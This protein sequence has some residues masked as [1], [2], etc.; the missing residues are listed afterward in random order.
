MRTLRRICSKSVII[1]VNPWLFWLRTADGKHK[2]C[3]SFYVFSGFPVFS[4]P[5]RKRL[6]PRTVPKHFVQLKLYRTGKKARY[7]K[8]PVPGCEVR[9]ATAR[10]YHPQVPTEPQWCPK[11]S[12]EQRAFDRDKVVTLPARQVAMELNLKQCSEF[13]LH[14]DCP[15][16]GHFI[17]LVRPDAAAMMRRLMRQQPDPLE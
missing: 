16:C 17:R 12:G 15:A 11:C 1:R 5:R 6:C 3:L 13:R 8:C 2:K 9:E 10:L 4:R 7:W 14:F